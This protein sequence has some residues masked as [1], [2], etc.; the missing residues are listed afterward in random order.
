M[1]T[2]T[3]EDEYG[4]EFTATYSVSGT[5][6]PAVT[7]APAEHCHEAEYPEVELLSVEMCGVKLPLDR[8][9]EGLRE[10]LL[11]RCDEH[12]A[13]HAGDREYDEEDAA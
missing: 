5:Y 8:I 12:C 2:V 4:N 6:R 7:Q 3:H 9:A 11:E 10:A 1:N 13:E